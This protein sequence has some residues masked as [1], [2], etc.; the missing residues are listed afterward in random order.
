[1]TCTKKNPVVS[2][3]PAKFDIELARGTDNEIEFILTDAL[4]E[5]VSLTD[6]DVTFT[7]WDAIGGTVKLGPKINTVGNHTDP[8]NGKTAFQIDRTEIDDETNTSTK[9]FWVYEV[10]RKQVTADLENVHLTGQ[11]I[12]LPT[13]V[14]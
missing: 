7:A 3:A 8:Q 6:S 10:R 5:P 9:T 4:G 13:G 14:C 11:L 2:V 12:I 1:M